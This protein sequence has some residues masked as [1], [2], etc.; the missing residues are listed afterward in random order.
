MDLLGRE[1]APHC[2]QIDSFLS[3][4][5]SHDQKKLSFD[6][7]NADMILCS[8]PRQGSLKPWPLS[9]AARSIFLEGA[10]GRKLQRS[11]ATDDAREL[12]RRGLVWLALDGG[13]GRREAWRGIIV[14]T[15]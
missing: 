9:L 3:I 2:I 6:D 5:T 12:C 15:E 14:F 7:D 11:I 13:Q 4:A 10:I 1:N 8:Y